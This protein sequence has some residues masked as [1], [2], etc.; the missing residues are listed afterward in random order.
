[1]SVKL[2]AIAE[3]QATG[4]YRAVIKF[5]KI[6]GGVGKI[7]QPK[8]SLRRPEDL[9][10][11]LEN[12][13]ARLPI[14]TR[15][16]LSIIKKL[17]V[18]VGSVRHWTYAPTTGWYNDRRAFVHPNRVIGDNAGNRLKPPLNSLAAHNRN[19]KIAGKHSEWV[20]Q[21]A[22]PAQYSS[23]MVLA[24]CASFT[25]PLLEIAGLNSF[26]A[27]IRGPS[28]TGKSTALL[29]GASVVGF[30]TESELINFRT[31]DAAFGEVLG[32]FKDMLVPVNELGLLKGTVTQQKQ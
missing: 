17:G 25:A 7:A 32:S 26:G 24:I 21:V 1:M 2:I 5:K 19:L 18:S 30:D 9:L 27:H 4:E 13:G 12:R 6:D 23:R 15:E 8:S 16:A 20:R 28:K 31:T 3:D 14:D 10:S 22:T 29:A 11:E